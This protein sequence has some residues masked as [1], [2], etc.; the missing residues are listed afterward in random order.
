MVLS[1]NSIQTP[2]TSKII[3]VHICSLSSY[4]ISCVFSNML[5][6]GNAQKYTGWGSRQSYNKSFFSWYGNRI[7]N[8]C[9]KDIP[10]NPSHHHRKMRYFIFFYLLVS[11]INTF[12]SLSYHYLFFLFLSTL[13]QG[14]SWDD[15]REK[16]I[17]GLFSLEHY[18]GGIQ[19]KDKVRGERLTP[20]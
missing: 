9:V 19:S 3:W 17:S 12:M 15:S 18:L 13:I 16:H 7:F 14:P 5:Y 2:I 11:L 6:V 1:W 10:R 20:C 4:S 8:W